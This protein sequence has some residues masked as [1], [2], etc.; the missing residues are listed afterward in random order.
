[1]GGAPCISRGHGCTRS[2]SCSQP[3]HN[4]LLHAMPQVTSEGRVYV[5]QAGRDQIGRSR[6]LPPEALARDGWDHV[7]VRIP[8]ATAFN[9]PGF[10]R[11]STGL[12]QNCRKNLH[13]LFKNFKGHPTEDFIQDHTQLL[14][15]RKPGQ[16]FRAR[17]LHQPSS[18]HP[19]VL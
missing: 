11:T 17:T 4:Q 10:A 14:H 13:S 2:R 6:T 8:Q 18:T 19:K 7:V 12:S 15:K 1:M 5:S 3:R 9:A 16:N